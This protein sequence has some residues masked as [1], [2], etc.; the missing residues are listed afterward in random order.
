MLRAGDSP[1]RPAR[2]VEE[3]GAEFLLA[4]GRAAGAEE[5]DEGDVRRIVGNCPVDYHNAAVHADLSS[6]EADGKI[7]ASLG[8]MRALGVP[9]SWQWPALFAAEALD[10][11]LV[12]G[13][14]R[15]VRL[16]GGEEGRAEEPPEWLG[17]PDENPENGF[18]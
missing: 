3:N 4:L 7:E 6:R 9:G 15:T 8:R 13:G 5:K 18:P 12:A 14:T 2:A 11:M 10:E 16:L 1:S 17:D